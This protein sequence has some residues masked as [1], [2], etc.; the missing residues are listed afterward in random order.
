MIISHAHKFIFVK[1][2]KTA[3]TSIETFLSGRCAPGDVVTP[4]LPPVEGH[5]ARNFRGMFNPL[6][7][8]SEA[9]NDFVAAK[10]VI[11]RFVG[12]QRY[13]NHMPAKIIRSRVPEK[14]WSSYFKFCVERNPWDKTLSYFY[15]LNARSN[16]VMSFDDYIESGQF[17]VD[18]DKYTDRHGALMVD[19]VIKYE[20]MEEGLDKVF[21]SLGIEFGGDLGV[22]AKSGYR[23][24]TRPYTEVF[25]ERQKDIVAKCFAREIAM[26]EYEY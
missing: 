2:R 10:R 3:G 18:L 21:D 4:V 16:G 23:S 6:T 7:D 20:Q 25:N 15:M 9:G 19:A 5:S 22:R 17:P 11:R 1:T 24:D 14:I 12:M 8:L 13:Y 26:H